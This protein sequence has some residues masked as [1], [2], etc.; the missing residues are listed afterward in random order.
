MD[1]GAQRCL[2]SLT[3]G[4]LHDCTQDC[5]AVVDACCL[6]QKKSTTP[7]LYL[8]VHAWIQAFLPT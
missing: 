4:A 5:T 6:P 2:H 3:L 1:G 7:Y 8:H